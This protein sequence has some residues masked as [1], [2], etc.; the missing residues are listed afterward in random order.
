MG[1]TVTCDAMGPPTHYNRWPLH[2]LN[3][4]SYGITELRVVKSR[5]QM[6]FKEKSSIILVP[7]FFHPTAQTCSQS[8]IS[9]QLRLLISI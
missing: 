4:K 9:S 8:F 3:Y 7:K 2:A 6:N 5:K 1:L